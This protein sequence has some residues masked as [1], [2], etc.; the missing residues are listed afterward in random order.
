MEVQVYYIVGF[1]LGFD[2]ETHKLN[3][4]NPDLFKIGNQ[5]PKTHGKVNHYHITHGKRC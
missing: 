3:R 2:I 5:K 1:F 4:L